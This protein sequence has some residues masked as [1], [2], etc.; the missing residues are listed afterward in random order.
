MV[1]IQCMEL[2]LIG[3]FFPKIFHVHCHIKIHPIKFLKCGEGSYL[4]V[5]AMI[6]SSSVPSKL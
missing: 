4:L 5:R 1:P 3:I 6:S 2:E